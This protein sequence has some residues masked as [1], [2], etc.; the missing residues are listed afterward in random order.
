MT[1]ETQSQSSRG[2]EQSN[3]APADDRFDKFVGMMYEFIAEMRAKRLQP[4]EPAETRPAL[5]TSM[6]TKAEKPPGG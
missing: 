3:P 6:T 4:P 1:D 5:T 2:R